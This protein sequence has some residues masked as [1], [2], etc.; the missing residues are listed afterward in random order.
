MH[1]RGAQ[2]KNSCLGTP[3]AEE[4][5]LSHANLT[6]QISFNPMHTSVQVGGN[7]GPR[8][9]RSRAATHSTYSNTFQNFARVGQH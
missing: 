9:E 1:T 8:E 3:G 6:A 2:E 4:Q 7:N 5:L